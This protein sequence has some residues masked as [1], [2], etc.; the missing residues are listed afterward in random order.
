MGKE[1]NIAPNFVK[2]RIQFD[3]ALLK[4]EAA[5]VTQRLIC[6]C[7]VPD[8]GSGIGSYYSSVVLSPNNCKPSMRPVDNR[9]IKVEMAAIVGSI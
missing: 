3:K 2:L 5:P 7:C 9:I 1:G 6:G 4:L 8:L